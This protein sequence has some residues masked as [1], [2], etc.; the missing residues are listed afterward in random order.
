VGVPEAKQYPNSTVIG[1]GITM[2][3]IWQNYIIYD[4]SM[5]MAFHDE[6]LNVTAFVDRYAIRRYGLPFTVKKPNNR[7][8]VV[9]TLQ[10]AWQQLGSTVYN[11]SH[12]GGVTKNLMVT[13]PKLNA[14]HSGFMPTQ[15]LYDPSVIEKVW[16]M[17]LEVSTTS[18]VNVERYR[19]DLVDIT[20]QA[21]S[22]RFYAFYTKLNTSYYN[23]DLLGVRSNGA[24]MIELMEDLDTLLNTN[25]Y[26]MLGEWIKMAR[27]HGTEERD[28]DWWEFNAR[29][30]VTLWG[31]NGEISNYASKQWGGLVGG[32]HQP[33]WELFIDEVEKAV[34]NNEQF[35][36][37]AFVKEYRSKLAQPWQNATNTYPTEPKGDTIKVAC[38]LY[39]K[40]NTNGDTKCPNSVQLNDEEDETKMCWANTLN[41]WILYDSRPCQTN[42]DCV[43]K[44]DCDARCSATKPTD[45]L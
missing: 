27:K 4:E 35:D 45:V 13:Q 18:I 36:Q 24:Q 42:D 16:S 37:S 38:A 21:L 7:D 12:W 29:N 39:L 5:E 23:G 22:D 41:G 40:W 10:S 19:Y 8:D 1:V 26:W 17:F 9:S 3:G 25:R 44:C 32:Y 43:D 28:A 31:P 15:L 6:P 14:V 34:A 11:I 20:R 2:E 30:Q 33:Q